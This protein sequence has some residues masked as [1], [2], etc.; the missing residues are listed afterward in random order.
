MRKHSLAAAGR[1]V[2]AIALAQGAAASA[3]EIKV[4]SPGGF[5]PVLNELGPQFERT[6]GHKLIIQYGSAAGMKRQIEAGEAVDV[7]VLTKIFMDDVSKQ[8]KLAA[9]T[10]ADVGRSAMA[11]AV[12]VGAPKPDVD[13]VDA[14]KRAL[15]N[16]KSIAYSPEGTTGLHLTKVFGQLGIAEDMKAKTKPADT[17]ERAIQAVANGDAELGF[18]VSSLIL[19]TPGAELAGRLPAELQDY[20]VYG[21]AVGAAAKEA[22]AA[23]ALLGFLKGEAA[24]AVM[25]AKG[26]DPLSQ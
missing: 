10:R 9:G 5:R 1:I 18:G 6:T 24:A 17:P 12:R 8:G 16:A 19:H 14:F 2:F 15:A 25:K 3:A 4:L 23:R 22:E 11:L 13:S 26:I 21:V 7:V 20:V